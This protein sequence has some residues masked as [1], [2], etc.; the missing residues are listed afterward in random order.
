MRILEIKA[1]RAIRGKI[2]YDWVRDEELFIGEAEI[3]KTTKLL[4]IIVWCPSWNKR[5]T[6]HV[7][8]KLYRNK[9]KKKTE[10]HIILV[11][12]YAE[13]FIVLE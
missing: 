1:I 11:P 4:K 5:A 7:I 2:L 8:G 6:V 10:L 12:D 9:K 13:P 3:G